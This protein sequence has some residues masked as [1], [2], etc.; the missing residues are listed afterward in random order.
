MKIV[1]LGR[2][3]CLTVG[4]LRFG[5][6]KEASQDPLDVCDKVYLGGSKFVLKINK[7]VLNRR[8]VRKA[9]E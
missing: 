7:E 8:D 6:L 3:N 1:V 9:V 4:R 2:G 5:F